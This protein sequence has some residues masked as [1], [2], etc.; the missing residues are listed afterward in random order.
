M[1]LVMANAPV[2]DHT[3]EPHFFSHFGGVPVAPTHLMKLEIN[4]LRL[5]PQ[6]PTSIPIQY[7]HDPTHPANS[8]G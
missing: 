8:T 4:V 2:R 1:T 7:R 6:F 5:L 3:L